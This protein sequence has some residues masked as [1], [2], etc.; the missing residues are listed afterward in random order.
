M[1]R[2]AS[3]VE[4]TPLSEILQKYYLYQFERD[5]KTSLLDE[6]NVN[7]VGQILKSDLE[8]LKDLV[9]L[10]HEDFMKNENQ[11]RVKEI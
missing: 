4:N 2:A 11:L 8:E 9:F 5:L 3:R 6:G 10:D 1:T 7:E